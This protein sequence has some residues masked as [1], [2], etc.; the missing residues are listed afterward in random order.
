MVSTADRAAKT[1]RMPKKKLDAE[2]KKPDTSEE[3]RITQ[4]VNVGIPEP[5]HAVARKLA[6]KRKQPVLYLLIG[7]LEEEAKKEGITEIPPAPWKEDEGP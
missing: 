4:R 5:W 3:R 2:P 1:G 6:A 7:L